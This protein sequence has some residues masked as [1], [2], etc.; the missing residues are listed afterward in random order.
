MSKV[1]H[2][3]KAGKK[4]GE[5]QTASELEVVSILRK[6]RGERKSG[7]GKSVV[8]R[9]SV[10]AEGQAY[11]LARDVVEGILAKMDWKQ[12]DVLN[13]IGTEEYPHA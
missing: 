9:R 4:L 10:D 11:Q 13:Y 7:K 1:P 8:D 2:T 6:G 12:V 3:V 5:P